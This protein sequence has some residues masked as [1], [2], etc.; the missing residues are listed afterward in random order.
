MDSWPQLCDLKCASRAALVPD[1][2]LHPPTLPYPQSLP[3]GCLH[4][5]HK[6]QHQVCPPTLVGLPVFVSVPSVLLLLGFVTLIC[7]PLF[8]VCAF[9]QASTLSAK[10]SL[11]LS[12]LF[13]IFRCGEERF[14]HFRPMLFV[15]RSMLPRV[16]GPKPL[17]GASQAKSYDY[18][19]KEQHAA[20]LG[21]SLQCRKYTLLRAKQ[22]SLWWWWCFFMVF[23]APPFHSS[24]DHFQ[25]HHL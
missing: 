17:F 15:Y 16:Q 3:R 18:L 6:T 1:S 25:P 14:S 23:P 5:L 22:V 19:N 20:L 12:A 21:A 9:L 7:S 10:G 13:C 8:P 24:R 4:S 2:P 11:L